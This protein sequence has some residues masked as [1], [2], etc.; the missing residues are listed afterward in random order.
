MKHVL[1]VIFFVLSSLCLV[2]GNEGSDKKAE[3]TVIGK[4]TDA[5]GEVIAGAKISIPETGESV[6]SDFDG[7]F[8]MT[9]KTDKEYSI[10]VSTIGYQVLETK[11]SQLHVFTDLTLQP[12]Q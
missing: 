3:R 4:V 1:F 10:S 12:L 5:S 2:A 11:S 6:Y 9:L 7:N 8:K